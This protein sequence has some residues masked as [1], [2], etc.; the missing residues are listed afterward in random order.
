MPRHF[1]EETKQKNPEAEQL[2]RQA[3]AL[4]QKML[5]PEH[6]ETRNSFYNLAGFLWGSG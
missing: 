3:L 2:F 5:G 4:R 1:F 6:P